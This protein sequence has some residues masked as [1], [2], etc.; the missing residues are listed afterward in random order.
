MAKFLPLINS[1]EGIE[2]V[3]LLTGDNERTA[4]S[5]AR[6]LGIDRV[7]AEVLCP[8]IRPRS[9]SSCKPAE[10]V[11]VVGDGVNDAAALATA[12]I[13]IAIGSARDRPAP[14]RDRRTGV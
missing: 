6:Q 13:G 4:N 11:A 7:I 3:L 5:I 8:A 1:L 14:P 9:S 2:V 10:G 12:D